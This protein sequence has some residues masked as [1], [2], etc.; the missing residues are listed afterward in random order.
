LLFFDF[1]CSKETMAASRDAANFTQTRWTVVV[2][3]G[4]GD[5][6]QAEAA[7][8]ELF[9]RYRFPLYA[10]LRGKR[11]AHADAEDLLQGFFEKLIEKR[12][13]ADADP[14]RG[15]FRSFLLAS[16]QHFKAN[17]W[18]RHQAERRGGGKV[19]FSLEDTD[20]AQRYEREPKNDLTPDVQFD[21]RWAR[22][23]LDHGLANLRR[24]YEQAREGE[25]FATLEPL[26][27]GRAEDGYAALGTRLGLTVNGV[28]AA[29]SRMRLR[30]R[31]LIRREIEDTVASSVDLEAEMNYLLAILRETS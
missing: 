30:F 12:W 13:L 8:G 9:S 25:R 2:R 27:E 10:Y 17:D 4:N 5:P 6:A 7:L 14:H 24:E 31:D 16:L 3:A 21:R 1:S 29:V 23:V 26:L 18:R 19:V 11:H 20:V 28:K 15:R 22:E